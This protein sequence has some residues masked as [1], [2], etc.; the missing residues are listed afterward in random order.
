MEYLL[1]IKKIILCK[2][3]TSLP[4]ATNY[5]LVTNYK[6]LQYYCVYNNNRD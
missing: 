2:T 4:L 3:I 5:L 1:N 6:K